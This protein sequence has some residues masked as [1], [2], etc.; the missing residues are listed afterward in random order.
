ME[1]TI[2]SDNIQVLKNNTYLS[3]VDELEEKDINAILNNQAKLTDRKYNML[4]HY[5]LGE[6]KI[7]DSKDDPNATE[8]NKIVDNIPA[9]LVDT[10]NGFFIGVAPKITLD[11][12][13]END[14]LQGWNSSN[15]FMDKLN[16]LSK[17]TDIYGR[18]YAFVYQNDDAETRVTYTDP[19]DSVLIYDDS[20]D[21]K[22]ICFIRYWLYF[23]FII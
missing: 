15:S 11:N 9:E 8:N 16:E 19:T 6:H 1:S 21:R 4:M 13:H 17:L 2:I 20:V 23:I 7:L 3:S 18:A 12:D 5:Y 14:L 22:P 10:F